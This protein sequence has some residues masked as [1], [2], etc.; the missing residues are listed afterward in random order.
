MALSPNRPRPR[1]LAT[2]QRDGL[3]CGGMFDM[4]CSTWLKAIINSWGSDIT[5]GPVS[6]S[7]EYEHRRTQGR[8]TT[9]PW[10]PKDFILVRK[11]HDSS[12]KQMYKLNFAL[13]PLPEAIPYPIDLLLDTRA[14]YN[15]CFP[16]IQNTQM[17]V[18]VISL[19]N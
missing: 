12:W 8:G 9:R 2:C 5:N 18:K 11:V 10:L 15:S 1:Q 3:G 7:A 14:I 6:P 4:E 16:C 17:N 19:M 13:V